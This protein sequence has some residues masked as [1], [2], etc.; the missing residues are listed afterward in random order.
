MKRAFILLCITVLP[1]HSAERVGYNR[2]VRPILSEHCFHCHGPDG[3]ARK[4]NLRLDQPSKVAARELVDRITHPD[5]DER[6]PPADSGRTLS[7]DNIDVLRRWIAQGAEYEEHWSFIR[8]RRPRVPNLDSP[9]IRNA[10]DGFIL[11]RLDSEGL[12]FA[13]EA[14]RE[15][16]IRRLSLALIGLPPSIK[17]VDAFLTDRDPNA[18]ERLVDR[19]LRSAHYGERMAGPWLDAARFADTNG[20]FTDNERTMWPWRDWVIDAFNTNMPHDQF[21]VE[22]L[23]GDLLPKPTLRQKIATGFNRN[24]MVNNESGLIPEEFRVEY[25]ADRV[26]TTSTVW[27]GLTMECARCHDHSKYD[28]ISQLDYYRMFAHFNNVPEKGLDGSRGNAAPLLNV[29]LPELDAT[30]SEL[31]KRLQAAEA[32]F[33]SIETEIKKAQTHWERNALTD[34]PPTPEQALL[35]HYP[36]DGEHESSINTSPGYLDE[37]AEFKG[38]EV[39][40]IKT[41]AKLSANRPFSI[42]AWIKPSAAG[43]I[44]SKMDEADQMR[45]FDL[46]YRKGKV[47]LHLVNQWTKSDIEVRTEA[48]IPSRQWN[49][50]LVTYDG[51]SQAS[52]ISI[53]LN[54]LRQSLRIDRDNLEGVITNQEPLRIGRRQASASYKGLIDDVRIYGRALSPDEADRLASVQ[55]LIGA[56]AQEPNKRDKTVTQ[57]LRQ[58]FLQHHATSDQRNAEQ[59]V[60]RLRQQLQALQATRPTMMIMS[61]MKKPRTAHLLERGEYNKP[62][63]Q[64]HP[65]IP[66]TLKELP[67]INP[68]NRLGFAKWL[69][70]PENPLTSRVIVNRIWAQLFGRGIVATPEDFGT[71]GAWPEHPELLDWLACEFRD[72]GWDL[73]QLIRLIATSSTYRQSSHATAALIRRDP[74][75]RLL[76][77]GPRLR[78]DAETVRDNA[79]AAAGLL[80]VRHGGPA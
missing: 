10:I 26:K 48:S 25:V 70:H 64:V 63:D 73:K 45:G 11:R 68:P 51:S 69:M 74:D 21:T 12:K 17:E 78:L 7:A 46:V 61:E 36:L 16:L 75:N 43:C 60:S 65:D 27:M 44:V 15:M 39:I 37:A 71:Q 32:H 66:A 80:V 72:S 13:T 42:A 40:E 59:Q 41:A 49:H 23:A 54:G 35:A 9:R 58:H 18:H 1:L 2:D 8:P 76:A 28:T 30:I 50:L 55:F 29:A 57:R 20:Y 4:A 3:A 38:G 31:N 47:L 5:I 67:G 6:M 14:G 53:Y 22:Q 62:R 24:H 79:L 34:L 19:L 56:L 77:R 33:K 52:G